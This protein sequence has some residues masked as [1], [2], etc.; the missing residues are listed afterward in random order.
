M[1][2]IGSTRAA[3]AAAPPVSMAA[4]V[5][6]AIEPVGDDALKPLQD[7]IRAAQA[8]AVL[9]TLERIKA[10]QTETRDASGKIKRAKLKA[11]VLAL[12]WEGFSPRDTA[13]IL[14]ISQGVVELALLQL[15]KDA[16]LD[17]Q[18]ARIDQAIIPLAVD[19]LAR[20]V[21]AGDKEYTLRVLDGRGLLRSFKSTDANITKRNLTLTVIATMPPGQTV[22]PSAKPGGVMG[23]ALSSDRVL[24]DIVTV[25]VDPKPTGAV[26]APFGVVG[27]P[28]SL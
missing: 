24:P 26:P 22:L 20:G 18:I 14:G 15:R 8:A 7:S 17:D 16:S 9:D 10:I 28:D 4:D 6:G 25:A 21:I 5:M 3:K 27:V 2:R 13:R 1:P 12:R 11:S 23:K 19:N